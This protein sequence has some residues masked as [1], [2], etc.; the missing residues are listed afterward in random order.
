MQWSEYDTANVHLILESIYLVLFNPTIDNTLP[1][2]Y[3][4]DPYYRTVNIIKG[5]LGLRHN[6]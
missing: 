5:Q 4:K 2:Q 1:I 3:L 6:T